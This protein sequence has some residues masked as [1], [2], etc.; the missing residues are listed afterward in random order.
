MHLIIIE[1]DDML[2]DNL[3]QLWKEECDLHTSDALK[4]EHLRMMRELDTALLWN[5]EGLCYS[6]VMDMLQF[7]R[8]MD[9][10]AVYPIVIHAAYL[11]E[12]IVSALLAMEVQL[13]VGPYDTEL[14]MQKITQARVEYIL[15]QHFSDRVI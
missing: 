7:V 6:D 2:R 4:A 8:N 12:E 9:K 14:L 13:L 1:K 15:K 3:T 11:P 10:K 5:V